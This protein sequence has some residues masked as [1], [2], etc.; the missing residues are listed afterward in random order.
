MNEAF[1]RQGGSA[2]ESGAEDA[3]AEFCEKDHGCSPPG[4]KPLFLSSITTPL[5]PCPSQNPG[6]RLS[7]ALPK[8]SS[9]LKPR[10]PETYFSE[11][12]ESTHPRT[13]WSRLVTV[14]RV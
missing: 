12:L 4:R 8:T 14:T 6:L 11:L 3:D 5:K 10:L 9:R 2:D 1:A 13:D 7:R